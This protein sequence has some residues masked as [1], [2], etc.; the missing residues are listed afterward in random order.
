MNINLYPYNY[1]VLYAMILVTIIFFIMVL[2]KVPSL[3]KSLNKLNQSVEVMN[4]HSNSMNEKLQKIQAQQKGKIKLSPQQLLELLFLYG[5]FRKDYKKNPE[6]GV[7]QMGKSA[8]NVLYTKGRQK[9]IQDEL[10]SI[11]KN[12]NF[13]G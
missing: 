2:S 10:V 3:L 4:E 5:A 13:L 11:L 12:S 1:Y 6:N 9:L 8:T 7:K